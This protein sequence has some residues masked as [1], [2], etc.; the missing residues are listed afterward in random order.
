M[1]RL[2]QLAGQQIENE[3]CGATVRTSRHTSSGESRAATNSSKVTLK[4]TKCKLDEGKRAITTS[5][6]K[7]ESEQSSERKE[8]NKLGKPGEVASIDDATSRA[9]AKSFTA[10]ADTVDD[11]RFPGKGKC[12]SAFNLRKIFFSKRQIADERSNS[13][14]S[15]K[16]N[17]DHGQPC[18]QGLNQ[19][20]PLKMTFSRRL[21]FAFTSKLLGRNLSQINSAPTLEMSSR[22]V[23]GKREFCPPRRRDASEGSLVETSDSDEQRINRGAKS[24]RISAIDSADEL[25]Q[26]QPL[27]CDNGS[28]C[29]SAVD[30][31]FSSVSS[32]LANRGNVP[33]KESIHT[34]IDCLDGPWARTHEAAKINR[35]KAMPLMTA[36]KGSSVVIITR[37]SNYAECLDEAVSLL[38]KKGINYKADK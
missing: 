30:T 24:T 9:H 19:K 10:T 8:P 36:K 5:L 37:Y 33:I 7:T 28:A 32:L 3:V 21:S 4:W 35:Q 26:G 22:Q 23:I 20:S 1:H 14:K 13:G 29:H 11:K 2:R 25:D 15:I 17:S 16:M 38:I 12:Q 18:Q 31:P 6:G 34:T 27:W